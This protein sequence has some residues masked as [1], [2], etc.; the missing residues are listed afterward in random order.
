MPFSITQWDPQLNL[1]M[2]SN[3][4]R[5]RPSHFVMHISNEAI[6]PR[7]E[8]ENRSKS[9]FWQGGKENEGPTH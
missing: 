1:L 2:M 8:Y 7:N 4:S 5:R 6:V 9:T 3:Q